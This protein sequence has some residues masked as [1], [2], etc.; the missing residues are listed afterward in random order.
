MQVVANSFVI[1]FVLHL[2][3]VALELVKFCLLDNVNCR[4]GVSEEATLA[5]SLAEGVD[6]DGIE[7]IGRAHV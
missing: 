5:G 1:A 3:D 4:I 2:D 7:Q 6:G